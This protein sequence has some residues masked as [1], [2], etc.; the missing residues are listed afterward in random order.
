MREA[1]R[2]FFARECEKASRGSVTVDDVVF[3]VDSGRL[4]EKS[5]DAY[6]G[7]STLQAGWISQASAR[8]RRGRAGRCRPGEC[9]RLYSHARLQS[10]EPFQLPEL[11]RT[12]LDELCLQAPSPRTQPGG[13]TPS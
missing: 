13:I 2:L 9:F 4:K 11:K 5:F 6:T 8:Q 1:S 7:V 12:P 10:L 3:V